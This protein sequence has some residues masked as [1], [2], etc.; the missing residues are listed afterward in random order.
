MNKKR[1]EYDLLG[2]KEIPASAYYGIQ[3][4]RAVENFP[5]T[6]YKAARE[7]VQALAMVKK[8]AAKANLEMAN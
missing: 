2:S 6:G 5:I 1:L 8:A 3:T 4:Q 7:L